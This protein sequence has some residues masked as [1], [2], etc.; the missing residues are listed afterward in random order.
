[1][2]T[3]KRVVVTT[4]KGRDQALRRAEVLR[5]NGHVGR[6]ELPDERQAGR[7]Q[8]LLREAGA[9]HRRSRHRR[10]ASAKSLIVAP[11][12]VSQVRGTSIRPARAAGLDQGVREPLLVELEAESRPFVEHD[13]AVGIDI[14]RR[15]H[16][17]VPALE[18]P[19]RRIVRELDKR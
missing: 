19:A 2:L 7:A 18:G 13:L 3:R 6:W 17:V 1:M 15:R 9:R 12:G 8:R 5:Q 11:R 16:R 14:D 10:V 4:T